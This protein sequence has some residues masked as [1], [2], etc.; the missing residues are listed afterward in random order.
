MHGL[1][2]F[3]ISP[4]KADIAK[5]RHCSLSHF[6]D[7]V[8][9]C[10]FDLQIGQ[11]PL[12][13]ENTSEYDVVFIDSDGM[14]KNTFYKL[15]IIKHIHSTKVVFFNAS[16]DT[17]LEINAIKLGAYGLFYAADKL[18]IVLKG[19]SKIK[20]AQKWFRRSTMELVIN[21]L[22]K[23][24][25]TAAEQVDTRK[26]EFWRQSL[27]KREQTIVTYISQGAQNREIADQ[28]H[29]SVNTVKTH[30]YSIFRKTNCRNRVE[31]MSWSQ[32]TAKTAC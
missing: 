32:Q 30:I 1:K 7:L 18:D 22:L 26:S 29:I 16:D 4:S 28:L 8:D 5:N 20:A 10:G 15:P 6:I 14:D 9:A 24:S 2:A 3:V 17:E 23:D 31:L 19:I 13:P 21:E 27:T 12:S 25:S 11:Y